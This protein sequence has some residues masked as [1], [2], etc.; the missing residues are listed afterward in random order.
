MATRLAIPANERVTSNLEPEGQQMTLSLAGRRAGRWSGALALVATAG[1]A[2]ASSAGADPGG[3]AGHGPA[4]PLGQ[5]TQ[6]NLAADTPGT[7]ELTDPDAINAWGL[8]FGPA[9]SAWVANGGTGTASV[10]RGAVGDTPVTKI[11]TTVSIPGVVP[12]GEVFNPTDGFDVSGGGASGAPRFL[13]ATAG[14]VISGW[15]PNVPAPD[16]TQAEPAVTVPGAAFTGLTLSG[17]RLYAADFHNATVDVW[18]S[19]FKPV[20]DPGAFQD[21]KLPDGYAPFGI[22]A[23]GDE[24][25]VTYAVQD[26]DKEIDVPGAGHG[27]VDVYSTT[28]RLLRRLATAGTLNSPWGVAPA[29]AGFGA[30]SGALLV[31]NFGDGHVQAFDPHDGRFLGLLGD[32]QHGTLTVPGLWGLKFGN[33]VIGTPETLMF[34]AGPDQGT[35]GVFGELTAAAPPA[36]PQQPGHEPGH[37]P[38]HQPGHAP[39]HDHGHRPPPRPHHP[40]HGHRPHQSHQSHQSHH[41]PHR[42]TAPRS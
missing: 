41:H 9:S 20:S 3:D 8:A 19:A 28:G 13:F 26:A 30:A 27:I 38:P 35:H 11:P 39:G 21:R 24:I 1:L 23:V 6:R 15:S 37:Q 12:T 14:G 18:D 42:R 2:L 4:G 29:P 36:P 16:S 33:G 10:F 5:Y 31:G 34:T 32:K 40:A 25:V 22:Q 7:A 17:D